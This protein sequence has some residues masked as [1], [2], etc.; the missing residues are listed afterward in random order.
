MS[1]GIRYEQAVY[2]SFPFR[3]Q[4]YGLLAYSPG[5]RG[6]WLKEFQAACR[7]IGER[8]RGDA[9]LTGAMFSVRLGD[10][11]PWAIVG[12]S[13]P[14]ADDRGRPDAM[15]FHGL[16]VD[17]KE[18]RRVDY[19]PFSLVGALRSDWSADTKNLAT[20]WCTVKGEP[21]TT[22]SEEAKRIATILARKKKVAIESPTPISDLAR[23][24]WKEIP[25]RA[26]RRYSVATWTFAVGLGF[27]LLGTPRLAGM[28]LDSSYVD[29][30]AS[31]PVPRPAPGKRLKLWHLMAATVIVAAMAFGV[32]SIWFAMGDERIHEE[33]VHFRLPRT[34][35][36]PAPSPPPASA[37]DRSSYHADAV[38]PDE[39][40]AI[41]R[42]LASLARRFA[43][44]ESEPRDAT[45]LIR[46]L[47]GSRYEGPLLSEAELSAIANDPSQ[48]RSR[49][50]AWDRLIHRFV[51]DRPLP[52]DLSSG[53]LRWQIDTLVWSF[54]LEP[55]P[56]LTAPEAVDALADALKLDEPIQPNPLEGKYPTLIPYERFLKH[57]PVR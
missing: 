29:P 47:A 34:T 53:P 27:D 2:G 5:C 19:N 51:R 46:T 13:S 16:F 17:D 15:A 40:L 24:V 36:I 37:P 43:V 44:A 35:P 8:P 31:V 7:K 57:L 38:D 55:D 33:Y 10:R 32:R 54:H 14:G 50:L 21:S 18:F 25:V 3:D 49:A 41:E 42:G 45:N 6:E 48:G 56:K 23:A 12:I 4:G 1:G 22:S 52:P 26:R 28:E 20:G 39:R 9:D 30:S 11:G